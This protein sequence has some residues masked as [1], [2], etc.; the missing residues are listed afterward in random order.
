MLVNADTQGVTAE[1][2]L[3][4]Q[5]QA[6]LWLG[7]AKNAMQLSSFYLKRLKNLSVVKDDQLLATGWHQVSACATDDS[8]LIVHIPLPAIGMLEQDRMRVINKVFAQHFQSV[9]QRYLRDELG[10]CYAVFVM[11]HVQVEREGLVCAVQSSK[12][13]AHLLLKEISQCLMTFL[14]GQRE[15]LPATHADIL[16]QI[17]QLEQGAQH[18][19][20][21]SHRLFRRWSEQRLE[22]DA[23]E[24]DK[25]AQLLSFADI[26]KYYDAIQ[27]EKSWFILSNQHAS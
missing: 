5:P 13:E 4:S 25:T 27:D 22:K 23:K 24:E 12:V 19:E 14:Q 3:P 21:L 18:V 20:H 8:L 1:T 7:D 15:C 10:L 26:E 17:S 9:L 2:A 11:P 16:L 6:A